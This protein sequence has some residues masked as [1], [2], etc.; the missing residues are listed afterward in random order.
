MT[1]DIT[2]RLEGVLF[3][4]APERR[5]INGPAMDGTFQLRG[6]S[7]KIQAA[8]WLKESADRTPYMTFVL[9]LERNVKFY[10]AIFRT[11]QKTSAAAPD[12]FGQLNLGRQRDAPKLRLSGWRRQAQKEPRRSFISCVIDPFP[13]KGEEAPAQVPESHACD[14]PI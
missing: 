12:Y 14:L 9:E 2:S 8:A 3:T 10:G 13:P 7:G 1:L 6:E 5:V 11:Q 4:I